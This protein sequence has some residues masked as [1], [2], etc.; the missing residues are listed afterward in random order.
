[1][2]RS[3]DGYRMYSGKAYPDIRTIREKG[4]VRNDNDRKRA[5]KANENL[6]KE[7]RTVK[8]QIPK[9]IPYNIRYVFRGDDMKT[10]TPLKNGMLSKVFP[11]YVSFSR[12]VSVAYKFAFKLNKPI[13]FMLD[14]KSISKQVPVVYNGLWK[15]KSFN[16]HEKEV[17]LPP[18]KLFVHKR[19]YEYVK[20]SNAH[21][22]IPVHVVSY[23]PNK[24]VTNVRTG[25]I[26]PYRR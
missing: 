23:V 5:L 6:M 10:L 18:G 8:F 16:P 2:N 21:A 15:F 26:N 19:A 11:S 22:S 25:S 12:D 17:L 14:L 13:I 9:G 3:K 7:F 4:V 24:A 1:M 20:L